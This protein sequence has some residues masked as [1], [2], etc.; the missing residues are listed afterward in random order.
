M[1]MN[2]DFS[3]KIDTVNDNLEVVS[4]KDAYYVLLSFVDYKSNTFK[5]ILKAFSI[6]DYEIIDKNEKF[7]YVQKWHKILLSYLLEYKFNVGDLNGFEEGKK[8]MKGLLIEKNRKYGDAILNPFNLFSS[9][10]IRHTILSRLD[11]KMS[12]LLNSNDDEDEDII[13]DIMGYL[14][15]AII[16]DL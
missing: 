4:P 7:M 5:K 16:I 6:P 1:I 3:I 13:I 10:N 2:N 9:R 11:E 12:R 14:Y 8:F 15:F